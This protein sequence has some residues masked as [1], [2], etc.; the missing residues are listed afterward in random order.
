M[1]VKNSLN[2]SK[3][4]SEKDIYVGNYLD[5]NRWISY[6]SQINHVLSLKSKKIL[7]IG[8]GDNTITTVLKNFGYEVTTC[9]L[10]KKLSPDI[11][12]DIRKLPFKKNGFDLVLCFEVLEHI[13]FEDFRNTLIGINNITK[14][15]LII[16]LPQPSLLFSF[17]I[18]I[19]L[20]KQFAFYFKLPL[21]IKHKYNGEHYWEVEKIG[22]SRKRIKEEIKKSGFKILK[23]ENP[24]FTPNFLFFVLEK[25]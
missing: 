19:P 17:L 3:I 2:S 9:D 24:K 6:F 20:F 13:P 18:K 14:K 25:I 5:L 4:N 11:V 16:S 22:Y 8:I 1:D 23:E 10:N 12:A 15:Y 21:F 7:N